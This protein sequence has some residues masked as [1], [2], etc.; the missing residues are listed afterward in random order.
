M[1]AGNRACKALLQCS[2][3][4]PVTVGETPPC[5][6]TGLTTDI[7]LLVFIALSPVIIT[8]LTRYN[9]LPPTRLTWISAHGAMIALPQTANPAS[10]TV[11]IPSFGR[12]SGGRDV[13]IFPL[14]WQQ[15][16]E[17]PDRFIHSQYCHVVLMQ[18]EA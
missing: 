16:R 11:I 14:T 7:S 10:S 5:A 18:H 2:G 1:T 8:A 3:D 13:T 17:Q 4:I 15:F 12:R 6:Q 9:A